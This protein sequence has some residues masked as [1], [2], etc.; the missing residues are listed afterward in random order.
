MNDLKNQYL[1]NLYISLRKSYAKHVVVVCKIDV[2]VE[3]VVD[4]VEVTKNSF[5]FLKLKIQEYKKR[6]KNF[7]NVIFLPVIFLRSRYTEDKEG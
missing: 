3:T 7:K 1:L 4:V 5:P 6:K 2:V